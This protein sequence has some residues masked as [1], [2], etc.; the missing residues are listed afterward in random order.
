MREPVLGAGKCAQHRR[1]GSALKAIIR[2]IARMAV[3]AANDEMIAEAAGLLRAGKLPHPDALTV[4]GKT[5]THTA[6]IAKTQ[7]WSMGIQPQI[8]R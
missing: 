2:F 8:I 4:N 7:G 1:F 5:L 6:V 3:V